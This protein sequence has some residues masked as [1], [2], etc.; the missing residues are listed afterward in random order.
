MRVLTL[1]R[2][3][4]PNLGKMTFPGEPE[5]EPLRGPVTVVDAA[6][7]E[8]A[9]V[10]AKLGDPAGLRAQLQK[11]DA[12]LAREFSK[13]ARR[14]GFSYR[15]TVYGFG[16]RN[17]LRQRYGCAPCALNLERPPLAAELDG[18]ADTSAAML[19]EAAPSCYRRQE[20]IIQ[21]VRPE[22]RLPGG[23]FTSGII[24]FTSS[25]PY[26]RDANNFR[27]SWSAMLCL[28]H[29][30]RGGALHVPEYGVWLAV[31]DR[32]VTMFCGSDLW[33]AV[34]PLHPV[35]TVPDR[36]RY[37]IVQ[38]AVAGM[39]ACLSPDDELAH[40]RSART[41]AEVRIAADLSR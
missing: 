39:S 40:S 35:K 10:V 18:L 31:E 19:R 9:L 32:S 13:R 17:P 12:S 34:T 27:G 3:A 7:G 5:M 33:H 38:Y 26:H 6:T 4:I 2:Q 37:T 29:G 22:W 41:K 36:Y 24:N 14:A 16:A 1:E 21:P 28:R 11:L 30:I 8:P 25:L 23:L 20:E 15:S